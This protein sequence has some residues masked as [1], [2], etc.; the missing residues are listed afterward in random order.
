MEYL[1]KIC[2]MKTKTHNKR[3]NS[4]IFF[5]HKVSR[6]ILILRHSIVENSGIWYNNPMEVTYYGL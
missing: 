2:L 4:N 5:R 3:K 6:K 1:S